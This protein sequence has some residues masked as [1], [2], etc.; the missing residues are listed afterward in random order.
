MGW[1]HGWGWG[2]WLAMTLGSLAFWALVFWAV[3]TLVRSDRRKREPAGPEDIVAARFAAGEID[4][5][6]YRRRLQALRS[7]SGLGER[8]AGS[9]R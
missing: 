7:P 4:E 1:G 8:R 6:E 9:G 3:V 2:G 5:D